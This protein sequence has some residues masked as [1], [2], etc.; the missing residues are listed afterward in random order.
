MEKEPEERF[1]DC[2]CGSESEAESDLESI[3]RTN[4]YNC[5]LLSCPTNVFEMRRALERAAN[6]AQ[7]L[8]RG[9]GVH[10]DKDG[11]AAGNTACSCM[12]FYP[13]TLEISARLHT[14]TSC[15]CP[16]HCQ[17]V[18]RGDPV[19]LKLPMELNPANGHVN[20]NIFQPK[21]TKPTKPLGGGAGDR[22][23]S[24]SLSAPSTLSRHSQRHGGDRKGGRRVRWPDAI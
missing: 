11:A 24:S 16:P 18:M 7:I 10:G 21:P 6:T 4:D 12:R 23:I 8:L 9:L 1:F 20:V 17:C 2:C 5:S 22:P 3:V 14:D 13:A 15:G 19:T